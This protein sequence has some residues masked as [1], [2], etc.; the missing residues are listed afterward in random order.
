[1]PIGTAIMMPGN[2]NTPP[3][4]FLLM[5]GAPCTSAYPQLRAWLLANGAT[6]NGNG[7]PIIE[8][9]GG[10]F[11]RGWR[12]VQVVDSGRVFGSAQQDAFQNHRHPH[13]RVT[14][15][16]VSSPVNNNQQGPVG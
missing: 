13:N 8:D 14:N 12:P 2:G 5:N 1:M 10:Y 15:A 3:P 16:T 7:D 6:V 11:P 4:G 9:L